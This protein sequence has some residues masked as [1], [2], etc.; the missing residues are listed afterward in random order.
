MYES[1]WI[2]II[3]SCLYLTLCISIVSGCEPEITNDT[4]S[5]K[6]ISALENLEL[7]CCLDDKGEQLLTSVQTC[8]KEGGL[9]QPESVCMQKSAALVCCLR[10]DGTTTTTDSAICASLNGHALPVSMC[11]DIKPVD[12]VSVCCETDEGT[13]FMLLKECLTAGGTQV[14]IDLCTVPVKEVCCKL[15][16][17][18]FTLADISRGTGE[19]R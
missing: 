6:A 14:A 15:S 2:K 9:A 3:S 5:G 19:L 16:S 13:G 17:G 18:L 4:V 8:A 12:P 7:T 1:C 10:K 11:E